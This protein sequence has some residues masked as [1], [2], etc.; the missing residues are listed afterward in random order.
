MIIIEIHTENQENNTASTRASNPRGDAQNRQPAI[1][2]IIEA[3]KA[4]FEEI[5]TNRPHSNGF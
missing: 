1:Q 4:W 2:K 3:I 5:N